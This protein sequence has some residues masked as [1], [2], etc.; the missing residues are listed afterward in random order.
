LQFPKSGN[1]SLL[2]SK[3]ISNSYS[4][5]KFQLSHPVNLSFGVD[6]I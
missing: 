6:P 5:I 2:S 1:H 4:L 3:Q